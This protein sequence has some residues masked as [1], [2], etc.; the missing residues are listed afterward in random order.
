MNDM[1]N[2]IKTIYKDREAQPIGRY[3]YFSVLI[4]LVEKDGQL[5]LLFEVR[6]RTL[7]ADPGEI[8]FPGGHVEPGE[9]ACACAV[10]ETCEE[11]GIPPQAI[12][13]IGAGDILYGYANYTMYSYVGIISYDDYLKAVPSEEE[14]EELFLVPL[15]KFRNTKPLVYTAKVQPEIQDDFPFDMLG[16]E[17]DYKWRIGKW[18]IPIYEIDGRMIWGLTARIT[19]SLLGT[20]WGENPIESHIKEMQ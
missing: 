15:E 20:I 4:P 14:V 8:C 10:R 7:K 6:S 16:I 18:G 12:E 13:V 2:K 11:V 9:D 5:H 19:G 17:K 1:L 3:R